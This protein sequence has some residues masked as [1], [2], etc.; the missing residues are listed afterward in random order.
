MWIAMMIAMMLP[1]AMPTF[2]AYAR[3]MRTGT[4]EAYD[5]RA[6][7][8]WPLRVYAFAAGYLLVWLDFC[9]VAT[10]LQL[11]LRSLT[12]LSPAMELR[13]WV[14]VTLLLVA[15]VYQLTGAK[16]A[17]LN[18]CRSPLRSI[19]GHWLNGIDG[20][21]QMGITHGIFCLGCCW[22][23]M[24]LLFVF[25]VMNPWAIVALTLFVLLEKLTPFGV[26]GSR[27]AGVLLIAAAAWLSR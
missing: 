1:T 6:S 3:A 12:L 27:F 8:A 11:W 25:G 19:T 16:R 24:L 14:A 4:Q 7:K 17:C 22:A 26:W 10:G 13:G 23:L 9:I 20:A 15:G 18:H 21:L 2:V 5:L